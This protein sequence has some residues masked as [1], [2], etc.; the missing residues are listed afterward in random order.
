MPLISPGGTSP[1]LSSSLMSTNHITG[2]VLGERDQELT[3]YASAYLGIRILQDPV[4]QMGVDYHCAKCLSN[5][6]T[7][8]KCEFIHRSGGY[9]PYAIIQGNLCNK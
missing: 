3:M 9:N 5:P 8:H 1:R 2:W 7:F 4:G 6:P